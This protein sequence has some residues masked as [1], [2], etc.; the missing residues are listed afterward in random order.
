[1]ITEIEIP[2]TSFSIQAWNMRADNLADLNSKLAAGPEFR[3]ADDPAKTQPGFHDLE[4]SDGLIRG[5]FSQVVAFEV[6][7][8]RSGTTQTTTHYRIETAEAMI[9]PRV[10]FTW[11][12][13]EPVKHLVHLLSRASGIDVAK[14]GIPCDGMVQFQNRLQLVKSVG[15]LNPKSSPVRKLQMTGRIEDYTSA[16]AVDPKNH[17]LRKVAGILEAADGPIGVALTDTGAIRLGVRRGFI[18]TADLLLWLWGLI[19]GQDHRP[20]VQP[21][22]GTETTSLAKAVAKL[23]GMTGV[24][25]ITIHTPGRDP[26]VLTKETGKKIR[27]AMR[28]GSIK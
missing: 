15:V 24:D 3:L 20:A 10:A 23:C 7:E 5:Q 1:M 16:G 2:G 9:F 17:M 6:E 19:V 14:A 22:L 8:L 13:S 28:D 27:Q 4:I 11:G 26:V 18:A 12:K 25:S 21:L